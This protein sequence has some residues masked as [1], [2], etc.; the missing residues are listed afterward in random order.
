M[1]CAH[2]QGWILCAVSGAT[3]QEVPTCWDCAN[4]VRDA[5]A[6]V[7]GEHVVLESTAGDDHEPP[8]P[9]PKPLARSRPG[10][11]P[12]PPRAAGR[13]GDRRFDGGL[14]APAPPE[15]GLPS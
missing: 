11:T 15:V 5:L 14:P 13:R 2:R 9:G 12:P 3:Q 7:T 8:G 6:S 4:A 10:G 1:L